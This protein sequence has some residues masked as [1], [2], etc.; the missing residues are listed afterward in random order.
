MAFRYQNLG[1]FSFGIIKKVPNLKQL[2]PEFENIEYYRNVKKPDAIAGWGMRP[3]SLEGRA[4]AFKHSLP[5][6]CLEDGFLRSYDLGVNGAQPLSI[7]ADERG[8][9]CDATHASDIE[10]IIEHSTFDKETLEQAKQIITGINKHRLSKYNNNFEASAKQLGINSK[11]PAILIIDQC[12][13]DATVNYGLSSSASFQ[14]MIEDAIKDNPKAQIILKIHPDVLTGKRK[15][16]IYKDIDKYD[17]ITT[18]E[19]NVNPHSLFDLVDKVY[20]VS[21]LMGLE[22]LIANKEVYTYGMPFYAGWGLTKDAL[23]NERRTKKITLEHLVASAYIKYSRY[24]NPFNSSKTNALETIDI[25]S[26]T[27]DYYNKLA[28]KYI[29]VKFTRWKRSFIRGFFSKPS[30]KNIRFIW[31]ENRALRIAKETNSEIIIWSS[32]ASKN[33]IQKAHELNIKINFVEDGFIRSKGLGANLIKP[34]SL[35]KDSTGIY[36]DGSKPSDLENFLQTNAFTKAQEL[37]GENIIN[38]LKETKI[39]KYNLSNGAKIESKIL[40][41]GQVE[42][43]ASIKTS[44]GSIKTNLELLEEVR[45]HNP[46]AKI[47]YKDHPDLIT[48]KRK[49]KSSVSALKNIAD[50]YIG[51]GSVYELLENVDELHT[52]SSLS[53]FEALTKGSIKVFTYGSPFY[54]GWGLTQDSVEIKR[55]TKKLNIEQLIYGTLIQYPL[56]FDH[57]SGLPCQAEDVIEIIANSNLL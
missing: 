38:L 3:R 33:F 28:S 31:N 11:K 44:L 40:V 32:R 49:R 2:L 51:E 20:T 36:Y 50:E 43:D 39:D 24:I 13:G 14:Q 47:A 53:G 22:G 46:K 21:S 18:I 26:D 17:N 15:G 57:K 16:Y 54:A 29:A 27:K 23:T 56:Y 8:I 10:D 45:K 19:K 1:V 5:Y 48:K 37:R 6:I 41:I 35:V 12:Y 9:Y 42:D 25:L 55:R 4:Y 30:E 34:Y 7:V 52:I